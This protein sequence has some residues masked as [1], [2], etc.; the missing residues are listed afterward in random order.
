LLYLS[1]AS[2]AGAAAGR[3]ARRVRAQDQVHRPI[4]GQDDAGVLVD[5]VVAVEHLL[6]VLAEHLEIGR[7]LTSIGGCGWSR[8]SRASVDDVRIRLG[9][10]SGATSQPAS[11]FSQILNSPTQHLA[12]Q[13]RRGEDHRKPRR[14]R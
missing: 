1:P 4:V 2:V 6:F 8:Q 14:P 5:P 9:A 13:R 12:E 7:L 10:A 3:A 11:R